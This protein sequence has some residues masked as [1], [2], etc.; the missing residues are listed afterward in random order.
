M[1][2]RCLLVVGS[3]WKVS[4]L[5]ILKSPEG[6]P[7]WLSIHYSPSPSIALN[8][9]E[10]KSLPYAAGC[11]KKTGSWPKPWQKSALQNMKLA[12]IPRVTCCQNGACISLRHLEFR[13]FSSQL[14]AGWIPSLILF[15]TSSIVHRMRNLWKVK[16]CPL[17]V[18]PSP[19][20]YDIYDTHVQYPAHHSNLE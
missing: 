9:M 20:D 16:N 17:E 2:T 7:T 13:W 5:I 8:Q 12:V 4:C 1:G 6:T 19:F 14:A 10:L 3:S 15:L 11:W 18:I